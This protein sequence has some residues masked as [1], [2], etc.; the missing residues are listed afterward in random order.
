MRRPDTAPNTKDTTTAP[1]R[2]R[3]IFPKMETKMTTLFKTPEFK[4]ACEFIAAIGK[5]GAAT[6]HSP[7]SQ[8]LTNVACR[9]C[10][11]KIDHDTLTAAAVYMGA[12]VRPCDDHP[13]QFNVAVR[14]SRLTA[15]R[16]DLLI[17]ENDELYPDTTTQPR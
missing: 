4:A 8:L 16:R 6:K 13:T 12:T 15:L 2:L 3:G 10:R 1:Q 9:W 7:N 5:T 17:R 14:R 11:R